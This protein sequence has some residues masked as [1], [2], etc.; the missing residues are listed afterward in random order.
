MQLFMNIYYYLYSFIL[1]IPKRYFPRS[2]SRACS[3]PRPRPR[4]RP[5]SL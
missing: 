3:R 4:P 1:I 5:R 2:R